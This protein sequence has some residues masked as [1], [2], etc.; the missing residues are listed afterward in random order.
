MKKIVL[1][2]MITIS[3]VLALYPSLTT[4]KG[5]MSGSVTEKETGAPLEGVTINLLCIRAN[6]FYKPSPK[7]DK[8]GK[9]SVF[10]VRGGSWSLDFEKNGYE[11]KKISFYVDTTP[12]TKNPRIEVAL[13]KIEGPSVG[14]EVLKQIDS[15]KNF[16][17]ENDYDKALNILI[18]VKEK[19]KDESGIQIVDLYIGNCYSKKKD[20]NKSV[21]YYEKALEKFPKNKELIVSIGNAYNNL[22]NQEKAMEWFGKLSIEDIGNADTLYN[23]GVMAYNNGDFTNAE[24]YFK[25]AAEVDPEF[26]EAFYQLGMTYTA[27][28]RQS[29]AVEI[30]KKFVE[31]APGSPNIETA[32]AIIEAFNESK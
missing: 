26:A 13:A 21:E 12:G 30:L 18:E 6:E 9:W 2:A 27:L 11:T 14:E 1:T 3:M 20:Y 15:A 25:K 24:T 29:E 22:Q 8:E 17:A 5:K 4:G 7:T 28:D 23:I 31:M 10:F 32:K 19:Y 16:M